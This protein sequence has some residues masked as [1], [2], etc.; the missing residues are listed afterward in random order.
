MPVYVRSFLRAQEV[1][2]VGHVL[3]QTKPR[4]RNWVDTERLKAWV[5]LNAFLGQC[6]FDQTRRD[7]IDP[8]SARPVVRS[9]LVSKPDDGGLSRRIRCGARMT[10]Q[11]EHRSDVDDATSSRWKHAKRLT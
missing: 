8:D 1:D 3:R 10:K 7:R 2:R 6:G 5:F 4:E 9:H 11:P